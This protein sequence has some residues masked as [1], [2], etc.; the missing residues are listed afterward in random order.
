MQS[1][2]FDRVD[3]RR[4]ARVTGTACWLFG[5]ITLLPVMPSTALQTSPAAKLPDGIV[6]TE[7]ALAE[8]DFVR[9][10]RI[11]Q[12]A[13]LTSPADTRLWTLRAMAYAGAGK[14]SQAVDSYRRALKFSPDFLPA[15]EGV[16][17]IEYQRGDPDAEASLR[18][19][20]TVRPADATTHAMLAAL[21]Y[22]A[23]DCKDAVAHFQQARPILGSNFVALSEFGVC[24]SKLD[25]SNESIP[26]LQEAVRLESAS[27]RAR[28][29]LALVLLKAKKD[30]DA[31]RVLEP[32]LQVGQPNLRSHQNQDSFV[33]AAEIYESENDTPHAVSLLRQAIALDPRDVQAYL[34][35]A[36]LCNAHASYQV[37]IDMLDFGLSQ[38]PQAAQIY[39]ARGVLYAQLGRFEKAM[40]DFEEADRIDP[41]LSFAGV[42]EGITETQVHDYSHALA[43]FRKESLRHPD[44]AFNQYLL[45]ETLDQHGVKPGST[46]YAEELSAATKAVQLDPHLAVAHNL[47]GSLYL[48]SGQTALA[49]EHCE[50]ALR[51]DP[52]N[53]EALYHMILALRESDRKDEIP[54]LTKK[55]VALRTAEDKRQSHTTRY[56]LVEPLPVPSAPNA[57][58][59]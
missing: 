13:L 37:G 6:E 16:A 1:S 2:Q 43:T 5:F 38:M 12:A 30:E 7:K 56:Q 22:Q 55:L 52:A 24:L 19:V 57:T 11:S 3:I 36:T 39:S 4:S 58:P 42:A 47:L 40:R 14:P 17:Q 23:G 9:A 26:V 15:L 49:V 45:A 33:L 59:N 46:D 32:E 25:R 44:N 21:R 20:L 54:A 48:K 28:Y 53:Q 29:N 34:S 8:K 27:H 10:L 51:I 50:A 18:R 31:L 35:F 41:R